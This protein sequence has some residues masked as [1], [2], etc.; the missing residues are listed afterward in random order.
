MHPDRIA[1]KNTTTAAA[2]DSNSTKED[3]QSDDNKHNGRNSHLEFIELKN[4][5]EEYHTSVRIIRGNKM[6]STSP[7]GNYNYKQQ[8]G[9]LFGKKMK[10][11][12]T[13]QCLV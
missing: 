8:Q 2:A 9:D 5:W 6:S 12:T 1:H 11:R 4:A 13:L 10:K 3:K 7:S